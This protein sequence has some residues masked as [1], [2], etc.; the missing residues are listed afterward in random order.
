MT[1]FLLFRAAGTADHRLSM[2]SRLQQDAGVFLDPVDPSVW[3]FTDDEQMRQVI[4]DGRKNMPESFEFYIPRLT[5]LDHGFYIILGGLKDCFP[6][7]RAFIEDALHLDDWH[8]S[9]DQGR[10]INADN[11]YLTEVFH[12]SWVE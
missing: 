12:D 4:R 11:N 5:F 7:V 9:D 6:S 2:L 1:E 10:E 8:I 3:W